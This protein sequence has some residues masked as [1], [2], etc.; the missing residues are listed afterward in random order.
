MPNLCQRM[1]LFRQGVSGV[2]VAVSMSAKSR[3]GRAFTKSVT[4]SAIFV[5]E[6]VN[7]SIIVVLGHV[8]PFFRV[9]FRERKWKTF[10][11]GAIIY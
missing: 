3:A 8:F 10:L 11:H 7:V 5:N 2:R 1:R 4:I 6:N 9:P